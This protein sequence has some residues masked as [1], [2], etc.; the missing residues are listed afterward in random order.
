MK[1]HEHALISVGYAAGI[2]LISQGISAPFGQGLTDPMIYVAALVG[3][4]IID[5]LDHPLYHLVYQRNEPHV[6]QARKVFFEKGFKAAAAYLN[7]VEDDRKFK[8]LLLHNVYSLSIVAVLALLLSIFLN[9]PVYWFIG[10]GAF[11]LHMLTDVYGDFKVLGHAD[12]WLWVLSD[13]TL[14]KLGKLGSGLLNFVLAWG[15]LVLLAFLV[16]GF[17]IGWQLGLP[18]GELETS[19][20]HAVRNASDWSWLA[21]V[22]LMSLSAYHLALMTLGIG[23][24]HKYKLEVG[25]Q[26]KISTASKIDSLKYLFSL[27][28]GKTPRNRR[29]LEIAVL[30]M[31][32]EQE[33]WIIFCAG[34]IVAALTAFTILGWTTPDNYL[35]LILPPIFLALLFGTFIHTTIGE[36]GGVLGVL[37]AWLFNLLLG[38][39]N[40]GFAW[41]IEQGYTVFIAAIS[42]WVMG[43]LGGIL[44]KGQSRMSLVA[45]SLHIKKRPGNTND[46]WVKNVLHS[47][48][49]GLDK[50]YS[51]AHVQLYSNRPAKSFLKQET[52]EMMVAPYLGNPILGSDYYHLEAD[53]AY[54]P[55]LRE[56]EYVLCDNKLASHLEYSRKLYPVMPR[57]RKIGNPDNGDMF[58]KNGKYSWS[59]KHRTLEL[60]SAAP[61][62]HLPEA[63]EQTWLLSKTQAEVLDHLVTKRSGFRTDLFVYPSTDDQDSVIVCGIVREYTSTKEYATVEAEAYAGN[64]LMALKAQFGKQDAI[65]IV[66]DVSARLFYP[67]TSFY[68]HALLN[69]AE[70]IAVL[71]SDQAG[72]PRKDM[73]FLRKSLDALPAKNLISSATANLRNKLIVL[74]GEYFFATAI[75]SWL[76]NPSTNPNYDAFVKDSLLEVVNFILKLMRIE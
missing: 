30:K 5:F 70:N 12:N 1:T 41:A 7:N 46:D 33:I 24:Y 25:R 69:W 6:A 22:P 38:A 37:F 4:E 73:T 45:F 26:E 72:F 50:G 76:V 8:G 62:I 13:Q 15:A 39:L 75:T 40:P 59:S 14:K 66:E 55:L 71:S 17:R 3:G 48:R 10:L 23:A 54:I 18:P 20:L 32:A 35:I 63:A 74:A 44:L 21:Y 49:T 58:W 2:A 47:C 64:V 34:L 65:E 31:Q 51:T 36:F 56:L 9:A 19:L 53:D 29:N 57:H 28:R 11:F 52:A 16:I 27:A 61:S 43:L 60:V 68:D 42:A 67:R